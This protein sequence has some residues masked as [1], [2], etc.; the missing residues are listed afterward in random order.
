MIKLNSVNDLVIELNKSHVINLY[1]EFNQEAINILELL[2]RINPCGQQYELSNNCIIVS[3][4]FK[5]NLLNFKNIFPLNVKVQIIGFPISICQKG[6]FG[7]RTLVMKSIENRK[8]LKIVLNDDMEFNNGG[9]T[10]STF[11]FENKFSSFDEY[12]N[13]LRSNYRRRI[14]K[15]LFNRNNIEIRKFDSKSFTTNHYKLYLSIMERTENPLETLPI[16]FFVDYESELYEFLDKTTKEII[17]FIQLKVIK[18]KLYFLFGGFRK[19]DVG[20]YDIYYN[21]ILKIIEVGIEKRIHY[22]DF[23]QTAE[24]CKLKVGCKEVP[25]Y[26][27][28]HHSNPILNYTIQKLIPLFSYKP[29][30]IEHHVFKQD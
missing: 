12:V 11:V 14:N 20:R 16:E 29:Y 25:K 1:N 10:L 30:N 15:A 28:V 22:I 17:G 9:R 27:Y 8:G 24:E 23:G 18:D 7:D 4:E 21:M 13:A 2:E 6:Y 26:L 19:E 3:Y 5:I